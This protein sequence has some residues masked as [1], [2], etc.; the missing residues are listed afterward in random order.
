[1]I[2]LFFCTYTRCGRLRGGPLFSKKL[3]ELHDGFQ[4]RKSPTEYIAQGAIYRDTLQGFP[5]HAQ[6]RLLLCS[7]PSRVML[8][9]THGT[10]LS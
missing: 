4:L 3:F 7:H 2:I 9:Y 1:M 6:A 5:G 8:V 10:Q